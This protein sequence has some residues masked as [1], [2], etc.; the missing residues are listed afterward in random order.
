M[1]TSPIILGLDTSA[2]YCSAALIGPSHILARCM[3]PMR[4]GHAEA[5]GPMV[6]D[7][8][9]ATTTR[10]NTLSKIVVCT[11]PGS[12]TGQR[13]ALS[14]AKGLAL[15]HQTPLI[16]VSTLEV[17]AKCANPEQDQ[18]L[19]AIADVRRGDVFWQRFVNGRPDTKPILQNVADFEKQFLRSPS[20]FGRLI[21]TGRSALTG[22]KLD[23]PSLLVTT[24]VLPEILAWI[25]NDHNA[26]THRAA[27]L[28][29]RPPDAKLP[30]GKAPPKS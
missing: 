7:L 25:G 5:L 24:K 21:G 8:L 19:T 18:I 23:A 3:M 28:Y 22:L 27:P 30:G 15:P 6:D 11:G 9:R 1:S 14:F 26:L 13:V 10:P 4:K 20:L 16:G 29:H 17:W 12:F 2:D